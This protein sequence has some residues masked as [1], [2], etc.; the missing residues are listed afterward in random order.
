MSK[1]HDILLT[2]ASAMKKIILDDT[3]SITYK[4]QNSKQQHIAYAPVSH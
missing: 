3:E 4:K 2:S 1:Q